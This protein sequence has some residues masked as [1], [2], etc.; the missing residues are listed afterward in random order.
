M[1]TLGGASHKVWNSNM[2]CMGQVYFPTIY[3]YHTHE[4]RIRNR[5]VPFV[6]EVAVF[7]LRGFIWI[8]LA[9]LVFLAHRSKHTWNVWKTTRP[10]IEKKTSVYWKHHLTKF[11][12][13]VSQQWNVHPWIGFL[14]HDSLDPNDEWDPLKG[15]G[16]SFFSPWMQSFGYLRITY[17]YQIPVVYLYASSFSSK[18]SI[19]DRLGPA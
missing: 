13:S 10:D 12:N 8:E 15:I 2:G 18:H 14:C 7:E 11:K 9:Q 4:H 3:Q 19:I 5:K 6:F 17:Q 1:G 16:T